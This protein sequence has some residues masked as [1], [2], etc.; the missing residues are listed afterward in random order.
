MVQ[1]QVVRILPVQKGLASTPVLDKSS[2]PGD[3]NSIFRH[4]VLT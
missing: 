1:A 3:P 2:V 4:I